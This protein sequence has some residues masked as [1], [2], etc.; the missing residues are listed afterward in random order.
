MTSLYYTQPL[1][2]LIAPRLRLGPRAAGVVVMVEQL[3][4]AA[5]LVLVVPIARSLGEQGLHLC[6]HFAESVRA[7]SEATCGLSIDI[8]RRIINR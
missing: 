2:S 5:G 8:D 7:L 1:V 4:F 6:V 3:G